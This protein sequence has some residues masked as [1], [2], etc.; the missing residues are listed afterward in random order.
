M[1]QEGLAD[2]RPAERDERLRR[3]PIGR[4]RTPEEI[5]YGVLYR[6]SDEASFVTGST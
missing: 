4:V 6:A 2:V 5:V 1:R 3:V